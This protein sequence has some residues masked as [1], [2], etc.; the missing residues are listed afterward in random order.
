[1]TK[2]LFTSSIP[3]QLMNM[4]LMEI[5]NLMGYSKY[6]SVKNENVNGHQEIRKN[7]KL[8]KNIYLIFRIFIR[9][10]RKRKYFK[11]YLRLKSYRNCPES[12]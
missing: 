7:R 11:F 8:I 1:M 10:E 2:N 5:L 3:P 6:D 12:K 9:G 4:N